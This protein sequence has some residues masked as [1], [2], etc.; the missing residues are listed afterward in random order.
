MDSLPCGNNYL[1]G[2]N[3]CAGILDHK[4][5]L[6]PSVLRPH[7]CALHLSSIIDDGDLRPSHRIPL[8]GS[9]LNGYVGES[10]QKVIFSG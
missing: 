4:R 9:L 8:H 3:H 7:Y 6:I 2:E 1:T 10:L 5:D